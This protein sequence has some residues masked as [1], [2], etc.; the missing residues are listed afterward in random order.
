MLACVGVSLM[1]GPVWSQ[2]AADIA[3]AREQAKLGIAKYREGHLE[4]AL[5]RLTRAQALYEAP[6]HLLFIARC[7]RDLGQLV[8]A[9]ET[10]RALS[11]TELG[12]DAPAP[13]TQAVQDG[14]TELDALTPRIPRLLIRVASEGAVPK[15]TLGDQELPA[16]AVGIPRP[17]NPGTH[18]VRVRAEGFEEAQ[19]SIELAE[20][21]QKVLVIELK[22]AS[23][24]EAPKPTASDEGTASQGALAQPSRSPVALVLGARLGAAVPA[25]KLPSE[26]VLAGS[27]EQVRFSEVAGPG[28]E[29][30]LRAGASILDRFGIWLLVAAQT[31]SKKG[32]VRDGGALG[33]QVDPGAP[34]LV[35]WGLMGSVGTPQ[36]EIGGYA[37]LGLLFSRSLTY[38]LAV[39]GPGAPNG[40][41]VE[42]SL[43]GTGLRLGGGANLPLSDALHLTPYG[44]LVLGGFEKRLLPLEGC[45]PNASGTQE[46]D[47]KD[48]PTSV[49]V[50]LGLGLE[51]FIGGR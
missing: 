50:S 33:F 47:I 6:V 15:L 21:E 41:N 7:Q 10:Y 45:L 9:S 44:T 8:E 46:V 23:K 18:V 25:G 11:R 38:P 42:A 32:G 1:C 37:E 14:R 51:Y 34:N 31:F 36:G 19:Q 30:E 27:G 40:C 35:S 48:S 39:A 13:F 24:S 5:D 16:Q 22:A 4:E 12:P 17:T 43:P 49:S 20:G 28:G 3:T 2:S 29:I 26:A